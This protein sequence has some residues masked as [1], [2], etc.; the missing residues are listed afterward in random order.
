MVQPAAYE[1]LWRTATDDAPLTPLPEDP[2][3]GFVQLL[4]NL[5][6]FPHE[7]G[8][9]LAPVTI[10][11][12][13]DHIATG[14]NTEAAMLALAVKLSKMVAFTTPALQ[15]IVFYADP[16]ADLTDNHRVYVRDE[17]MAPGLPGPFAFAS[18]EAAAEWMADFAEGKQPQAAPL[19]DEWEESVFSG[20][21]ILEAIANL[22]LPEAW[23]AL[24]DGEWLQMEPRVRFDP[25]DRR[26][27]WERRLALV[28]IESMFATREVDLHGVEREE[29][30]G[31]YRGLI[32]HLM[33]MKETFEG[34]PAPKLVVKAAGHLNTPLGEA[35]KRWLKRFADARNED[36]IEA[37]PALAR[38]LMVPVT[39]AVN[40]LRKEEL[41]EVEETLLETLV[42]EL[43]RNA[44]E[45]HSPHNMLKRLVKGLL[46]SDNVEEVYASDEDLY[47]AFK[48]ALR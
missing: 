35:G 13:Y 19:D 46:R 26:A 10:E 41:I 6:A 42:L 15:G 31:R 34:G 37:L 40:T 3:E 47:G 8:F 38:Q 28:L 36:P 17:E 23:D 43:V 14:D 33:A 24:A 20:L 9:S 16:A 48:G 11:R 1:R 30:S 7:R 21:N 27:G 25:K 4:D 5:G 29:L 22:P 32:L 12:P 2:F 39:R 18:L 44:A 45:A